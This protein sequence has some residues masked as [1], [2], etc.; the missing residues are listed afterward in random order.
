MLLKARNICARCVLYNIAHGVY[1]SMRVVKPRVRVCYNFA[2]KRVA[3][4]AS[5]RAACYV[6][7]RVKKQC[8]KGTISGSRFL[9]AVHT[10]GALTS[11]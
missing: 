3:K 4:N 1:T 7:A 11:K 2:S 6:L 8:R 10:S 5:A 9:T